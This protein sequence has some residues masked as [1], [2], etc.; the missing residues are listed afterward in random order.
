MP[1]FRKDMIYE[2]PLNIIPERID[3]SK[4]TKTKDGCL[5]I[6]L[7]DYYKQGHVGAV[8][9]GGNLPPIDIDTPIFCLE[10]D[11]EQGVFILSHED[12]KEIHEVKKS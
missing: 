9:E 7:C 11:I 5:R 6:K 8:K 10:E 4:V 1:E 12:L 2:A 3:T